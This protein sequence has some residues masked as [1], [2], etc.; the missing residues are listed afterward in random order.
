M[1]S[2]VQ[3]GAD[4]FL[5]IKRNS[6]PRRTI[7]EPRGGDAHLSGAA[8]IAGTTGECADPARQVTIFP[9]AQKRRQKP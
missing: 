4:F 6:V 2:G 1:A 5:G 8:G 7:P 9:D 3:D